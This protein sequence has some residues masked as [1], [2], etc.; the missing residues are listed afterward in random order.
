MLSLNII[1]FIYNNI[2]FTLYISPTMSY[3]SLTPQ[4]LSAQSARF[5]T[6]LGDR[7]NAQQI[8]TLYDQFRKT[9][10]KQAMKDP[11]MMP[12]GKYKGKTVEEVASFDLNY[13]QWM[14]KQEYLNA[15]PDTKTLISKYV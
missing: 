5:L 2:F 15:Y 9:E 4:K 14:A 3:P 8:A 6:W 1:Y 11:R 13:L 12:F 10:Y 7:E